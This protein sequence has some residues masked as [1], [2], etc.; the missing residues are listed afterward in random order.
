M[1]GSVSQSVRNQKRSAVDRRPHGRCDNGSNVTNRATDPVK[2]LFTEVH[3]RRDRPAW[4]RLGRSHKVGECLNIYAIVVRFW[5]GVIDCAKSDELA[6]RRIF[7]RKEGTGD[8]HFV[9]VGITGK[10][11]QTAVLTFPSKPA[12]A[13]AAIALQN[14][15]F[16][17]VALHIGRLCVSNGG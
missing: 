13:G 2:L 7:I 5:H 14:S 4:R 9:K 16:R 17:S 10:R 1:D 3:I 15:N 12:N 8:T 6:L 11:Y